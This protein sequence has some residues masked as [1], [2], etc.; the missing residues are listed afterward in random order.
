VC[1]IN[2]GVVHPTLLPIYSFSVITFQGVCR[3]L[4]EIIVTKQKIRMY[5]LL[6]IN[7]LSWLITRLCRLL[8]FLS[9]LSAFAKL[10]KATISFVAS[11]RPSVRPSALKNSA[12]TGGILMKLDI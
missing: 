6:F 10:L 7:F 12:P 1:K 3:C 8:F 9:L 11:V 2:I 5:L 4:S